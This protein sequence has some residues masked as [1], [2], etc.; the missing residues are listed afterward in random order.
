MDTETIKYRRNQLD[1][2]STDKSEFYKTLLIRDPD[3]NKT[4]HLNISDTEFAA[5]VTLLTT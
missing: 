2:I 3:G 4:N 1:R 5:I